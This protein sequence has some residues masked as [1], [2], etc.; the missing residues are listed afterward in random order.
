[1]PT[2][3]PRD[4]GSDMCNKQVTCIHSCKRQNG[5]LLKIKARNIA[6]HY[7]FVHGS[8]QGAYICGVPNCGFSCPKGGGCASRHVS[9]E[10]PGDND[11]YYTYDP[12]EESFGPRY[13][14]MKCSER[15]LEES[16]Q[17]Q[18]R[19]TEVKRAKQKVRNQA[20]KA[21][22]KSKADAN[23]VLDRA[24]ELQ[25]R[26]QVEGLANPPSVD[27]PEVYSDES[28]E[29]DITVVT[30]AEDEEQESVVRMAPHSDRRPT[31][32]VRNTVTGSAH[33]KR[34]V[35]EENQARRNLTFVQGDFQTPLSPSPVK[36]EVTNSNTI[37]TFENF[38]NALSNTTA[39]VIESAEDI[40]EDDIDEN[41]GEEEEEETVNNGENNDDRG[42]E[43][44][45]TETIEGNVEMYNPPIPVTTEERSEVPNRQLR[46]STRKQS[47]ARKVDIRVRVPTSERETVEQLTTG[48]RE[49]IEHATPVRGVARRVP[50][51]RVAV[52]TNASAN[53]GMDEINTQS[54][55][56]APTGP[57]C[58]NQGT[59]AIVPIEKKALREHCHKVLRMQDD[60]YRLEIFANFTLEMLTEMNNQWLQEYGVYAKTLDET[61]Y[62][63]TGVDICSIPDRVY[64]MPRTVRERLNVKELLACMVFA[65]T[66]CDI[67]Y[68]EMLYALKFGHDRVIFNVLLSEGSKRLTQTNID[69][70]NGVSEAIIVVKLAQNAV[71]FSFLK[72]IQIPE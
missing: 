56:K 50:T 3:V 10:H 12:N 37:M 26:K 68:L 11:T 45:E 63:A 7:S 4:H 22:K 14:N 31:S 48:V 58:F 6:Q 66:K 9:R 42:N 70:I 49:V 69:R 30:L 33:K 18:Q 15:C 44:E 32:V 40:N 39:Q 47:S 60:A 65:V 20:A 23:E 52:N 25:A 53:R 55:R 21:A 5:S 19:A 8:T 72:S 34:K 67:A 16:D 54:D 1:M 46:L 36:M 27:L 71:L 29:S 62:R 61:I 13:E 43:I 2:G 35:E 64:T 38:D 17:A 41:E 51:N 28:N 59:P 24:F 57:V